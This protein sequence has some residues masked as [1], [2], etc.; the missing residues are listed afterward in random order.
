MIGPL[1]RLAARPKVQI[2]TAA[3]ATPVLSEAAPAD[4]SRL[5]RLEDAGS[6]A[7][8]Q[9]RRRLSVIGF[10]FAA[11]F[12]VIGCRATLL[13][14]APEGEGPMR[15]AAAAEEPRRGDILDR[16]GEILASTLP[17]HSAFAEPRLVWDPNA[18]AEQLA[19]VLPD[20][21]VDALAEDLSADRG[22]VWIARGLTPRQRQAIHLLGLPGVGFRE[23]PGRIYPKRRAASHLIGYTD[24]DMDGLAGAERAFDA[25]LSAGDGRPVALSIDLTAQHAVERVLRERMARYQAEGASAVLMRVGTGEVI[26]LASLPDFDPNRPTDAPQAH[27]RND[28]TAGVHELGSVFKPLTLAA[29]LEGGSVSL[30]DTF[31]AIAP[32]RVDGFTIRDFHPE[33]RVLTGREVIVHSSNIGSARMAESIGEEPLKQFF[34]D[35]RLFEAA[36]IELAESGEPLYP[37][38]DWAKSEL[39]TISYGHGIAVSP[40]ALTAAYAALANGGVYTPPTLRPVAPGETIAGEPVMSAGAAMAVLGVMRQ[41]VTEGSGRQADVE[42]LAVAGKTGTAE[43]VVAGRYD[44]RSLRTSFVSVFPFDDPEYVL[45]TSFDRPKP[46]PETHGYATAGWNA[47]PT[48]GEIIA[49]LAPIL[50]VERRDVDPQA[51]ATRV[52]MMLA[53]RIEHSAA[54]E[55]PL[56]LSAIE[57]ED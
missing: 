4:I 50:G 18:T 13:A 16:D 2:E 22:F 39:M 57:P 33:R 6:S 17:F 52:R 29:G 38:G 14:A 45:L 7:L 9:S 51:S 20:I 46:A 53:P 44:R 5:L 56:A 32:L 42:G 27:R 28:A 54:P 41:V 23:E 40:L 31:D 19:T 11:A 25:A 48:A 1:K 8:E 34:A 35:L 15:A 26:A 12:L 47:A 55:T 21:N 30:D 36:P 43:R 10:I 37:R 49:L 3:P 24:R